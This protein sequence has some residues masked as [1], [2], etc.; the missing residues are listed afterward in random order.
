M[1]KHNIFVQ[2]EQ[3]SLFQQCFPDRAS[4][5]KHKV[6]LCMSFVVLEFWNRVYTTVQGLSYITT[7]AGCP[8]SEDEKNM[9]EGNWG[10]HT[11]EMLQEAG[12]TYCTKRPQEERGLFFFSNYKLPSPV[13]LNASSSLIPLCGSIWGLRKELW[14]PPSHKIGLM[15]LTSAAKSIFSKPLIQKGEPEKGTQT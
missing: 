13:V 11:G 8:T 5:E 15:A 3:I 6:F 2:K 4:P 9:S 14:L 12:Q 10:F 1:L 7:A